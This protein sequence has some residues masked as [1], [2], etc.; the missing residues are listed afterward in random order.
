MCRHFVQGYMNKC[1]YVASQGPLG[2]T[3]Y[4]FWLMIWEQ[5]SSCIIM[6]TNLV[7]KSRVRRGGG[8]CG[9]AGVGVEGEWMGTMLNFIEAVGSAGGLEEGGER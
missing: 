3:T 5:K 4:D 8:G 6:L 9:G 2:N 7:E 1:S